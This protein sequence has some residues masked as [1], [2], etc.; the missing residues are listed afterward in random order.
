MRF[1]ENLK[2]KVKLKQLEL[3]CFRKRPLRKQ[4]LKMEQIFVTFSRK[5]L[6]RQLKITSI[7][8]TIQE[9]IVLITM[10]TMPQDQFKFGKMRTTQFQNTIVNVLTSR[11]IYIVIILVSFNFRMLQ[12]YQGR[13]S[14]FSDQSSEAKESTYTKHATCAHFFCC[15][16][17]DLG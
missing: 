9:K 8:G 1:Q 5:N 15:L 4:K 14:Q 3:L 17:F 13:R 16:E 7:D 10:H 11:K 6:K 2:L 12:V